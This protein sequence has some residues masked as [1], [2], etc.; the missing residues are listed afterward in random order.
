M[1][2]GSDEHRAPSSQRGRARREYSRRMSANGSRSPSPR[3]RS[4]DVADAGPAARSVER[5]ARPARPSA[6]KRLVPTSPSSIPRPCRTAPRSARRPRPS[7]RMRYVLVAGT[8]VAWTAARSWKAW[9]PGGHSFGHHSQVKCPL[10]LGDP[11][12]LTCPYC[13][14]PWKLVVDEGRNDEQLPTW[15]A[16]QFAAARGRLKSPSSAEDK[17]DRHAAGRWGIVHMS[18]IHRL[19]V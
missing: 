5:I 16:R 6:G 7:V 15:E 4:E 17:Y 12:S 14:K 9:L 8:P 19:G 1:I 11:L 18:R 10:R 3:I 2:I 13:T